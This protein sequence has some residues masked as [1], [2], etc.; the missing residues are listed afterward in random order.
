MIYLLYGS[1]TTKAREKMREILASQL[2][3]N[4]DASYFKFEPDTW[5]GDKFSELLSGRGLFQKKLIVILDGLLSDAEQSEVILKSIKSLADSENIFVLVEG[6]L[7][8]EIVKKI[9]KVA[10]KVQVFEGAKIEKKEK[11]KIFSLTDALGERDKKRLWVLF[12][13]ALRSDAVPEQI[14]GILFWQIKAM[15]VASQ[16]RSANE[17]GLNPF[18]FSKSQRFA[19]NFT[20]EDLKKLSSDLVRIYHDS[21]RGISDFDSALERFVL[22]I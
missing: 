2:K 9:E 3:K 19:K 16:S 8:K 21:H 7:T 13:K 15:L 10:E 12:Q 4:P 18:V 22:T 11:F 6:A 1:N 20:E 14:H 5:D 17:S